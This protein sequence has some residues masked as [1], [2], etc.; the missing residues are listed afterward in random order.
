MS[1]PLT[2]TAIT[3]P[4]DFWTIL[5]VIVTEELHGDP[6]MTKSCSNSVGLESRPFDQLVKTS[7]VAL[8]VW[9]AVFEHLVQFVK[10]SPY[11]FIVK[12]ISKV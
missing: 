2:L 6:Q 4:L 7:N 3:N 5:S 11:R 1:K 9:L 12:V 8:K 10:D